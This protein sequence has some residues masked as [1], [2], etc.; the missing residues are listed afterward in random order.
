VDEATAERL[1]LRH[2]PVD[3][4][5]RRYQEWRSTQSPAVHEMFEITSGRDGDT[6]FIA[7]SGELDSSFVDEVDKERRKTDRDQPPGRELHGLLG[8]ESA[9]TRTRAQQTQ[10]ATAAVLALS[11]QA[12]GG[13]SGGDTDS[14]R[15]LL[16][17]HGWALPRPHR[18]RLAKQFRQTT[19]RRTE[20]VAVRADFVRG[21]R[22][23]SVCGRR[24]L[25][26]CEELGRVRD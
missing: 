23:R 20:L 11:A 10:S 6:I 4:L 13:T 8:L 16:I 1:G 3:A 2:E 21:N 19:R 25:G 7:L 18:D 26:M 14:L 9:P 5:V 12:C 24:Q 22:R 15:P 17:A